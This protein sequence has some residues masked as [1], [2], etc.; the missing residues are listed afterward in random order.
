MECELVCFDSRCKGRKKLTIPDSL[1]YKVGTVIRQDPTD[2]NRIKCPICQ[3]G[4]MKIVS[5]IKNNSVT[6]KDL[7]FVKIVKE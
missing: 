3:M 1:G 6:G 4:R 2:P 5:V 7:G